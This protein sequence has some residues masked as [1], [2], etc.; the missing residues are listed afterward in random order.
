[1]PFPDIDPIA[2][3]LGPL[4]IRWYALAYIAGIVLGWWV[5][6]R[7]NR[8]KS[9]PGLTK[10]AL[11]DIIAWAVLGVLLGG[12]LGY[13]LFYKPTYYFSNPLEIAML[14]QGGM[15]FHGGLIGAIIAF[16]LFCRRKGVAFW[17]FIDVVAVATPIG[18]FFGRLANFV[19]GELY[20][21]VTTAPWGMVFP[22]GGELPRH[23]SQLYEAGLE[24][25]LLFIILISL[26]LWT[27]ARA[28]PGMLAGIF[29]IGYGAARAFVELF[30]QPDA[31]LGFLFGTLTMGQILCIPMILLGIYLI[32]RAKAH[33]TARLT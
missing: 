24:G 19:N 2:L 22:G 13:V 4:A 9:V 26:A 29:L 16:A 18:L 11:D 15:S 5:I 3:Q 27:R 14:W 1:M 20:G 7:L 6:A 28:Y 31:H 8:H 25:L 12:R 32:L 10:A 23:P 33:G 17:P 30:R 21:R